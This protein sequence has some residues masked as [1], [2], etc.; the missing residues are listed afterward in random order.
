M[1]SGNAVGSYSHLGKTFT[2]VDESGA[3]V[4]GVIVDNETKFTATAD[5][6]KVGKVAAT[7]TGVTEGADTRTYRTTQG[8]TIVP[9]GRSCS[10]VLPEYDQYDYTKLQC[11]LAPFNSDPSTS[12]AVNQV[13]IEN[14]LYNAGSTTKI[15]NVTKNNIN[16]SIDLNINNDTDNYIVIHYFTYKEG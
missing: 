6:I 5:D 9:M 10:I 15:A 3:E 7:D 14:Y 2:L 11:V 13:V 4:I 8:R 1:I 16:K 12:V